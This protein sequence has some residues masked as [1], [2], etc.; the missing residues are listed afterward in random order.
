MYSVY[1]EIPCRP[2]SLVSSNRATV[3]YTVLMFLLKLSRDK[4]I[5]VSHSIF[6]VTVNILIAILKHNSKKET[7]RNEMRFHDVW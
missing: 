5:S 7:V 1:P 3:F 4:Y 6:I 2:T